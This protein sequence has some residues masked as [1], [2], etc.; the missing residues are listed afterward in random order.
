MASIGV[1]ELIH[2]FIELNGEAEWNDIQILVTKNRGPNPFSPTYQDKDSYYKTMRQ[3]LQQH[4]D[5]SPGKRFKKFKGPAYFK[6]INRTRFKLIYTPLNFITPVFTDNL[7][8]ESIPNKHDYITGATNQILINAYERDTK[9]RKECIDHYGMECS[10]C[11]LDFEKQYG[12][13]GKGFI[14]VHHLKPLSTGEVYQLNPIT[15][16]IPVCPNCH[17]M[18]HRE[19]PPITI[20]RLKDVIE[21]QSMR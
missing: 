18:L 6:Q 4:C 1:E 14:H 17:S 11:G 8:P 9:A 7:Y 2:A 12:Q 20:E 21:K 15:D 13:I 19:N 10:V 3:V 16:L 5:R